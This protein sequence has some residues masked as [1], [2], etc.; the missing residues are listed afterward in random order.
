MRI[1]HNVKDLDKEIKELLSYISLTQ[2]HKQSRNIELL[3][4]I[5]ALFVMPTFIMNFI[6]VIILP[7]IKGS[8]PNTLE[9][10]LILFPLLLSPV[11]YYMID[12]ERAKKYMIWLVLFVMGVILLSVFFTLQI[13]N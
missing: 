7:N 10:I 6:G 9:F 11:I 3:T 13:F 1:E 4:I 2:S 8:P 12:R 5:G